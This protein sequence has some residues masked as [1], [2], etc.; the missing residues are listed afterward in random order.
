MRGLVIVLMITLVLVIFC[1]PASARPPIVDDDDTTGQW[2]EY[3]SIQE[4]IDDMSP[5]QEI[6]V[7]NGTYVE[8]LIINK[9]VTLIGNGSSNTTIDGGDSG[10]PVNVMADDVNIT[11]FRVMG[12]GPVSSGI[13]VDG[14]R[15]HIDNCTIDNTGTHNLYVGSM[16]NLAVIDNCTFRNSTF[17]LYLAFNSGPLVKSCQFWDHPQGGLELVY[18]TAA[19][20]RWNAF[21]GTNIRMV[22]SSVFSYDTHTISD[23]TVNGDPIYYYA[24]TNDV[25][26]PTDAGQVILA[27]CDSAVVD[28]VSVEN[29]TI[30]MILAFSDW[31]N[32]TASTVDDQYDSIFAFGCDN[33]NISGVTVNE[34]ARYGAFL[35]TVTASTIHNSSITT[36]TGFSAIDA[37]SSSDNLTFSDNEISGYNT[38]IQSY[39]DTTVITGGNITAG[40]RGIYLRSSWSNLVEGCNLYDCG[41][42]IVLENSYRSVVRNT[43]V[44]GGWDDGIYISGGDNHTIIF[45]EIF[46]NDEYAI[47][48][49]GSRDNVIH[50]NNI[51]DNGGT[52]SQGFDYDGNNTWDDDVSEGNYW[53]DWGGS[54]NYS[55]DGGA[56]G[57]D[58]YPLDD[59]VNTSA[60]ERIPEPPILFL[61]LVTAIALI[62]SVDQGHQSVW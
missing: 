27:D 36:S 33:L 31:V 53:D 32:V 30:G 7:Y 58:R 13:A 46:E 16:D 56:G 62:E 50:H 23:C 35:D 3:T 34:S 57:V 29:G 52:T 17:G 60:P 15:Y 47:L 40:I 12:S 37:P 9:T 21:Y 59:P 20:V 4:C 10:Y 28:G 18:T 42:G 2:S 48:I 43:S 26:V 54:G 8:D 19:T 61:S 22:G 38:G 39:A 25:T 55:L 11:G 14:L 1:L 45:N 41:F 44:Q 6:W 24:N 5:G 51:A 49:S